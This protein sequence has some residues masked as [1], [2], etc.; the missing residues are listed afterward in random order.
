MT[1]CSRQHAYIDNHKEGSE[2]GSAFSLVVQNLYFLYMTAGGVVIS[3]PSPPHPTPQKKSWHAKNF[4]Q[5]NSEI[6][7]LLHGDTT[8][9]GSLVK[10]SGWSNKNWRRISI[11]QNVEFLE[12]QTDFWN[13]CFVTRQHYIPCSSGKNFRM[14]IWELALHKNLEFVEFLHNCKGS[15]NSNKTSGILRIVSSKKK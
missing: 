7:D 10:K 9:L 15:S 12:F 4:R 14:I 3:T 6:L 5:N 13:S 1:W 11:S 8:C 2:I